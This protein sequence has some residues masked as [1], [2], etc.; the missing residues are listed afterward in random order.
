MENVRSLGEIVPS[1]L[2]ACSCL[3]AAMFMVKTEKKEQ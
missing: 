2:R 1:E 3:R